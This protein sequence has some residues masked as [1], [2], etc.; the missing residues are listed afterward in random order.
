M[1]KKK[2][3]IGILTIFVVVILAVMIFGS[4]STAKSYA[5]EASASSYYEEDYKSYLTAHGFQGI[6]SSKEVM[7]DL[8]RY[9]A[10]D[11]LE[12]SLGKEGIITGDSG[13]ITFSFQA[14]E[15]G[16]YNLELGYITQPGTT[17][18]I[19]R[20]IFIN[21]ES[22][23]S[24]LEQ[25]VLKRFWTDEEIK[26]KNKN[27]VRPNTNEVYKETKVFIEDYNRRTGEPYIFY[28][29]KGQNT[30]TFEVIKEPIE[31]TSLIFK[32][33]EKP[34]DYASVI[35]NLKQT[36]NMYEGETIICQ[37]ERTE[38]GTVYIEKNAASIN[39]QK[40]Y[41]DS[42]LVPY[43]PYHILYN[44]IG[45]DSWKQP[46]NAI[47]WEIEVPQEGLYQLAFKGRQSLK[48][49]VTA[50]RRLYI[51]NVVPYTEMNAIGFSYQGDVTNYIVADKN[52]EPYLFHL[53]Q[54]NNTIT[55]ECVMGNMGEII[56]EVETSM[57][58]LN[59]TYL[60]V[61]KITGQEPDKF[62]DYEIA[63]KIPEFASVMK[64]ESDRLFS[65]VNRLVEITG[66]KGENTS[67][68]EKMAIQAQGLAKKPDSVTDEITQLKNNI[69]A[70]GT[71]LVNISEMPLEL[72]SILLSKENASLPKSTQSFFQSFYYG[73]VRFLSTFFVNTSQ[74]SQEAAK[75]E[76]SIKVWMVANA[77]A[78]GTSSSGREQAQVIQN[79]IDEIFTPES[80]V[81]VNLQLIPV[82][83]VLRAALAGNSPDVVIGLNQ[84]TLQDFAMRNAVIDLS[85]LEGFQEVTEKYYKSTIDAA[86]Y[87]DGVYGIP[88]QATFMMLFCRDDILKELGVEPPKTWTE[89][90]E[91]LPI[92][93]KNNYAFYLP[94]VKSGPNVVSSFIFQYGGNLYEG[95]GE[96]YGI[97][98]ALAKEECMLAFKDYTDLFTSYGLEVQVDFPNRF[99][100]GEMPL[101]IANY[102]TYN[103]LEIFA[104]EIKGVW[105]F[106]PI[107]GIEQEDGTINNNYV[108]DTVQSTIMESSNNKDGAWEFV[109]W[110]TSTQTQLDYANTIESIMGAAARYAAADPNVLKQLPWS[111]KELV[112]L[113]EQ[114]EH[115][116]GIPAIP[117]SYMSSR[118]VQYAF[119]KVVAEL[120]NPRE[121]LYL[122][123]KAIDKE[124][125]KKREE[126]HLSTA[127]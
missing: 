108:I 77:A 43:H 81:S 112:Q 58:R 44:T 52:G 122:N 121:T 110:W 32:Q 76:N 91:V 103:Q 51:N 71:W 95:E 89:V 80:G 72:D 119:D 90:K 92:L 79:L 98:S 96:D 70:L 105:S 24:G 120:A 53:K 74:I 97:K 60:Q 104:P 18:D 66:E 19:Q 48:R 78:A 50:Y 14:E 59:Q 20:K 17:S 21:G 88:E 33:A 87:L 8:T 22:C 39:I 56:S 106:T 65:M 16:F 47:T 62:I 109:K 69:S 86:S 116:I 13:K 99:R 34:L 29:E 45:A 15:T 67:L 64:E 9:Q 114:M 49:G 117:G 57:Y 23:Y 54:G 31:F 115:T 5:S 113:T 6:L 26:V 85:K 61:V 75:G 35:D 12:A 73:T 2:L 27:E 46:G 111:N 42:L 4:N 123:V 11:G 102:T 83:V 37:A 30:I 41:S 36:Y 82:D 40:N 126:F 127:E 93:Q 118:M 125:L 10:E 3:W 1:K 38:G 25:I 101:G 68:L 107:P 28:L 124:L 100:T 55:L 94:T 7:V 63:K 84:A